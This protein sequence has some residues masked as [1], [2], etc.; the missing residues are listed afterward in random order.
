MV[1]GAKA[2]APV[3]ADALDARVSS[4]PGQ[5]RSCAVG[6]GATVDDGGV[7]VK[8]GSGS[9]VAPA[10]A[11]AATPIPAMPAMARALSRAIPRLLGIVASVRTGDRRFLAIPFVVFVRT[12]GL[13]LVRPGIRFEVVILEVGVEV[14][15]RVIVVVRIRRHRRLR[16]HR[17]AR[18]RPRILP[19][20]PR[21]ASSRASDV[22]STPRRGS[23]TC[24]AP[25]SRAAG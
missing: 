16:R 12:T 18:T 20:R 6:T 11:R 23:R 22:G 8:L 14:G 24:V 17:R 13:P 2:A 15:T 9:Q 21:R 25:G 3:A 1:G 7:T 4:G 19:P 5:V 10:I